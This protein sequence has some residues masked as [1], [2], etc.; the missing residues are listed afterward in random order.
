MDLRNQILKA[1]RF[2]FYGILKYQKPAFD[3]M[4]AGFFIVSFQEQH[5]PI[6]CTFSYFNFTENFILKTT[7]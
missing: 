7:I 5:T 4:D 1:N 3:S 2:L 6:N